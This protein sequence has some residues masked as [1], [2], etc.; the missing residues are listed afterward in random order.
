MLSNLRADHSII[1]SSKGVVRRPSET[2]KVKR[3]RSRSLGQYVDCVS[4]ESPDRRQAGHL[5]VILSANLTGHPYVGQ[6][7]NFRTSDTS[8]L[9]GNNL[10]GERYS[11]R[12]EPGKDVGHTD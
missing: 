9:K 4:R 3:K 11:A 12:N 7:E 2:K 1:S 6:T 5:L 8:S 10:H